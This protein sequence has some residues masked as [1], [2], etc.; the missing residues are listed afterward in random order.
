MHFRC[1]LAT[2]AMACAGVILT[3][4]ACFPA[5]QALYSFV[6]F[7]GFNLPHRRPGAAARAAAGA[8]V[9]KEDR[10]A[11]RMRTALRIALRARRA[12]AVGDCQSVVY[13]DHHFRAGLLVLVSD[14]ILRVFK[15][16]SG[17]FSMPDEQAVR[18]A[19][20]PRLFV[21]LRYTRLSMAPRG[22]L[23]HCGRRLRGVAP[24]VT[25]LS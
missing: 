22:L 20:L 24:G 11:G 21:A 17:N 3:S 19:R 12:P 25:K 5:F 10:A 4:F 8:V 18:A 6:R 9:C 14:E 2:P 1:K 16:L 13:R 15:C 23:P 7:V